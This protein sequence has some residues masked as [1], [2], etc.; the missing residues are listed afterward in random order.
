MS[1]SARVAQDPAA[2]RGLKKSTPATDE[3]VLSDA[4]APGRAGALP[5]DE[6]ESVGEDG[7]GKG[8]DGEGKEPDQFKG[9]RASS[10][11]YESREKMRQAVKDLVKAIDAAHQLQVEDVVSA[12]I[13]RVTV[14]SRKFSREV[15]VLKILIL[16]SVH[17]AKVY[18]KLTQYGTR[19]LS[20]VMSVWNIVENVSDVLNILNL[21]WRSQFWFC[22]ASVA[23]VVSYCVP[24]ELCP[25]I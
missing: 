16:A 14:D 3:G 8:E 10:F 2:E 6:S 17:D 25:F 5:K 7:E 12:W 13:D 18:T 24:E 4:A 22:G 21:F 9:D 20:V 11:I 15:Q 1:A 19:F 23:C